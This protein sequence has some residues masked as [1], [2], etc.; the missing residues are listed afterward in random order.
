MADRPVSRILCGARPVRACTVAIIPL[1][2]D[3][4]LGSSSLPEGHGSASRTTRRLRAGPALPSYLAL[5][6]AGF[7]VPS[8]SL[9]TRWALTPP[10]HPYH[11]RRLFLIATAR[12]FCLPAVTET[13]HRRF[14]F[15]G[16]FR[17]RFAQAR[18]AHSTAAKRRPGVTRRVALWLGPCDPIPRCPDFPP[19]R[20]PKALSQRSPG[21][22]ATP[23][24]PRVEARRAR[25]CAIAPQANARAAS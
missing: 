7:S 24:I 2:P 15:C 11:A 25:V 18:T 10:F 1:G 4:H 5:H 21:L 19:A 3:S 23:I 14:I 22:P 17:R 6:H 16:T 8:R 20:R 13:P 9:E 12:R